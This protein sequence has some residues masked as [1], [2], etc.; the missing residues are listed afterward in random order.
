MYVTATFPYVM[1]FILLVKGVTLPGAWKGIE[2]YIKPNM[3]KLLEPE[4]SYDGNLP[5]ISVCA[6]RL[7]RSAV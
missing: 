4:V 5:N 7:P 6:A 2:F 1:L 3:A